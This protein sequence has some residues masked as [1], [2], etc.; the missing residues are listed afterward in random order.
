MLGH[1]VMETLLEDEKMEVFDVAYR[2]KLREETRICDVSDFKALE[3]T[4]ADVKPDVIVNC[5]GILISGAQKAPARAIALN[6][7]LPHFLVS[8]CQAHNA[9]LIHISTDCVFSGKLGQYSEDSFR[10]ADDVYGRS[11]ALGEIEGPNALTLRTSII[12]PEIKEKGEGLIHWFLTTSQQR[13]QGY[14]N[15]YWGGV[16][17]LTCSRAIQHAI[18]E[19]ISGLWNLTNGE[20]ISKYDLLVAINSKLPSAKQRELIANG[21]KRADKSLKSSRGDIQFIVPSYEKMLDEMMTE[22]LRRP[23]DYPLYSSQT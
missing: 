20:A 7:L 16:T 5:V 14:S 9:R 15:V 23:C 3:E 13:I 10:D 18:R 2:Q 19:E 22:I 8:A 21:E 6:S 11:K 1:K 4:I 12:G 17:T